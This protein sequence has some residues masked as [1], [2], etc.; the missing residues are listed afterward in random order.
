[1]D[2]QLRKKR[3]LVTG[4]SSGLG[5]QIAKT[6]AQE[7][8]VVFINSRKK[9]KAE[10][11]VQEIV[12]EGG[13]AF[14]AVGDLSIDEGARQ[15]VEQINAVVE[16][17]D[18]LV[19]N[20][21]MFKNHNWMDTPADQWSEIYNVNVGSVVRLVQLLVPQMKQLGWGRIIQISSG[22]AI[23]PF[24]TLPDY[25]AT[26]AA[27]LSLTVSLAK[28]LSQTGITV[29]SVSPGLMLTAGTEQMFLKIA[30]SK[31]WG[32]EWAEIEKRIQQEYWPNPTG[33]LGKVEEVANLVT[34]LASP[35]AN[36]INGANVPVD[37]GGV[38]TIN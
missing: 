25:Q 24:A 30:Q 1:M 17:I 7:G 27:A 33:R 32:T 5:K 9:E 34:Y 16:S 20:A 3:A 19:N 6:L 22:L 11:V 26:K 23:Q 38:G 21:G 36:Y 15:I 14:I 31:G 2:L 29:N 37:G 35:V 10:R 18:I 12:A 4:S 28:E 8:V 13:Q